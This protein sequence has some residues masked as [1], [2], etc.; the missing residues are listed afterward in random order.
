MC[1]IEERLGMKLTKGQSVHLEIQTGSK[2]L[3]KKGTIVFV[4]PVVDPASGLLKV[5]AQF[6]NSGGEIWPG[7]SGFMF[8]KQQATS[9]K[10]QATREQQRNESDY[11]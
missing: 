5:K 7:V 4:S 3:K 6:D 8:L 9:N 10:Q 1:N 11:Q 2:S